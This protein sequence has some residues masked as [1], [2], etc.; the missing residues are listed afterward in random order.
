MQDDTI[1]W[2]KLRVF[3]VVCELGS[4]NSASARLSESTP[5]ISRKIDEL[6]KAL[7]TQL[8]H[9]STKGVRPTEAG[10]VALRHAEAMRGAAQAIALEVSD[11]NDPVSGKISFATGDGL[12]PYWLAPR[13]PKFHLANPKV[14]LHL[15]VLDETPDVLSGDADIAIQ[16]REPKQHDIIARRL[17]VLHYMCFASQDY[18][19]TYGQP[20]SL[21][22]LYNHRCL[23]HEAYVEQVD[24]WAPKTSELSR[25]LDYALITNSGSAMLNVCAGGGGIAVMPSYMIGADPRLVAL[26]L[27]EVA[28]ITFWLPYTGRIR[29][30]ARGQAVIEWTRSI[31]DAATV[32]WFRTVFEHPNQIIRDQELLVT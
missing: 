20:S 21:F 23:F 17:G 11:R 31:F 22:E 9:R 18:I 6:E 14:E 24:S 28:P 1:D 32:P 26:D 7:N 5:T 30:L 2:D 15:K 12:G 29:R 3:R 27:P 8:L 25:L 10:I 13:L 16:F 4:M 19:D